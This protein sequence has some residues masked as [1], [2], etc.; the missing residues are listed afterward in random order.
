MGTQFPKTRDALDQRQREMRPGGQAFD[1]NTGRKL[2]RHFHLSLFSIL[3]DELDE[4][5]KKPAK[6]FWECDY[7]NKRIEHGDPHVIKDGGHYC[8]HECADAAEQPTETDPIAQAIDKCEAISNRANDAILSDLPT[9]EA[10]RDRLQHFTEDADELRC[11]LLDL[12]NATQKPAE[13]A[14]DD[15]GP[16]I[17]AFPGGHVKTMTTEE[18]A[19]MEQPSPESTKDEITR[20][21]LPSGHF[22]ESRDALDK[23]LEELPKARRNGGITC[24]MDHYIREVLATLK[25]QMDDVDRNVP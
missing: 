24:G 18:V 5:A 14:E 19:D 8:S 22:S 23:L 21:D 12:Q 25:Q 17:V 2:E 10:E 15:W 20:I 11:L 1:L 13:E 6:V 4:T 3:L 9:N 16:G 7:C